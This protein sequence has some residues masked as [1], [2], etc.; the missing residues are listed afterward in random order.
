MTLEDFGYLDVDEQLSWLRESAPAFLYMI[1]SDIIILGTASDA[2]NDYVDEKIDYRNN[3]F[4][5]Y[6]QLNYINA[7]T[8]S[9]DYVSVDVDGPWDGFC[10]LDPEE[11]VNIVDNYRN[12]RDYP[13]EEEEKQEEETPVKPDERCAINCEGLEALI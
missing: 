7:I 10:E 6:E 5:N 11:F 3:W 8:E 4:E 13:F 9:C 1:E 2:F 12:L